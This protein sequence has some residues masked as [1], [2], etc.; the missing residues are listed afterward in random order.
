MN[1]LDEDFYDRRLCHRAYCLVWL[2][3]PTC[4]AAEYVVRVLHHR[5][6]RTQRQRMGTAVRVHHDGLCWWQLGVGEL[7]RVAWLQ[8]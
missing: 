1:W 5:R 4:D 6:F 2:D 7:Q 3:V 8:P